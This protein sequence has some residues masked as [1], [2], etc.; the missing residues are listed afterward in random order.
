MAASSKQQAASSNQQA[1]SSSERTCS[2][3]GADLGTNRLR[4]CSTQTAS[5][6]PSTPP[7]E[8]HTPPLSPEK[9][10]LTANPRQTFTLR[11]QTD[12][13]LSAMCLRLAG[14]GLCFRNMKRDRSSPPCRSHS[15]AP[16]GLPP[17]LPPATADSC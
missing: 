2:A 6:R 5:P 17:P 12:C 15:S 11:N 8:T 10:T 13:I 3:S 4:S 1:A 9:L 16:I 7:P 14:S